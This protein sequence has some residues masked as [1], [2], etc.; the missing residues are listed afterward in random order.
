MKNH[1]S[2]PFSYDR[3]TLSYL[4]LLNLT[5]SSRTFLSFSLPFPTKQFLWLLDTRM[6]TYVFYHLF[7]KRRHLQSEAK[8]LSLFLSFFFCFLIFAVLNDQGSYK[9]SSF[10]SLSRASS[11]NDSRIKVIH[12]IHFS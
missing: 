2:P 8:A 6:H 10:F 9:Y 5:R 11:S 4:L 3:V 1:C 12:T 7:R